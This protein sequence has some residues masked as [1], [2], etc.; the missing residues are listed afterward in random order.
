MNQKQNQNQ[1]M[2]KAEQNP[3]KVSYE[4]MGT[5]VD[6]DPRFVCDYLVRGGGRVSQQEVLLFMHTC[7]AMQLNPM[8]NGEVYLIKYGNDPAQTVVGK[9]AYL[10]RAFENPDYICKEDG[11]TVMRKDGEI[12]QKEGVCLYPGETLVGGWCRVHYMRAGR[13]RTSFKELALSEYNKGMANWK[14]RPATMICKCAVVQ[15]IRE[16]FPKDYEGLYTVDELVASGAVPPDALGVDAGGAAAPAAGPA[17]VEAEAVDV[18]E[19]P[20]PEADPVI[21]QEQRQE[22][23]AAVRRCY[24]TPAEANQALKAFIQEEGYTA[25]ANMPVSVYR[26]V[27]DRILKT[28]QTQ[29]PETEN[30]PA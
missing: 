29:V 23:F 27:M 15:A 19:A 28:A 9:G 21:T 2:T 22:M 17:V 1:M 12:V 11:V 5:R 20:V 3:L 4:V 14:T 16:A 6:L 26:R 24:A 13:E 18:T 25:T 30:A 10:R 7:Q 8:V